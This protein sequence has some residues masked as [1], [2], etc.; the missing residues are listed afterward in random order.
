M[1]L[2]NEIQAGTDIEIPIAVRQTN[3]KGQILPA[4]D[5][6]DAQ[7]DLYDFNRNI[8]LTKTLGN[9][10]LV[11]D[12]DGQSLFIASLTDQDTKDLSGVYTVA[13][14]VTD[15]LGNTSMPVHDDITFKPRLGE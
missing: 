2:D 9:G 14:V 12:V 13:L 4:S 7:L 11:E 5:F 15:A 3:K 6:T 1:L 8:V 10:I